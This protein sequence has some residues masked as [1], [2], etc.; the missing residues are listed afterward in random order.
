MK[1][2]NV[3]VWLNGSLKATYYLNAS[4]PVCMAKKN[5]L[6]VQGIFERDI[7]ITPVNKGGNK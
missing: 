7:K 1:L 2:Y 4:Y 6:I 3:Q 5:H